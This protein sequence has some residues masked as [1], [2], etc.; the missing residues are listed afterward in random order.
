MPAL[1]EPIVCIYEDDL[2]GLKKMIKGGVDLNYKNSAG[3]TLLHEA[4]RCG[5]LAIVKYLSHSGAVIDAVNEQGYT[6]LHLAAMCCHLEVVRYLLYE[7]ASVHLRNVH[8]MSAF[9]LA[10]SGLMFMSS[11]GHYQVPTQ[12]LWDIIN[13][14]YDINLAIVNGITN[15][16]MAGMLGNVFMMNVLIELGADVKVK[17]A[18]GRTPISIMIEWGHEALV[19]QV[20]VVDNRQE[21][22]IRD[23]RNDEEVSDESADFGNESDDDAVRLVAEAIARGA[24]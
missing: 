2:D 5:R 19:P 6:P 8:N 20:N 15:L 23:N 10:V 18:L 14:G 16:H 11:R 13:V 21:N 4:A 12:I 17:D 9:D 1:H 3:S 22:N 7:R 24:V